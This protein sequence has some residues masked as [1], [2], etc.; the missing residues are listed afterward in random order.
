M[1]DIS[2]C[3]SGVGNI[4]EAALLTLSSPLS[5]VS[6]KYDLKNDFVMFVSGNVI[7]FG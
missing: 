6:R 2:A 3:I 7:I 4:K 5:P 1:C